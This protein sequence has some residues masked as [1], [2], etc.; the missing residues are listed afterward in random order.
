MPDM[1]HIYSIPFKTF[2][3]P[4]E[5]KLDKAC[6]F[7]Y[8]HVILANLSTFECKYTPQKLVPFRV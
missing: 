5:D 7:T 1:T 4:F 8:Y 2:S 6:I 3:F